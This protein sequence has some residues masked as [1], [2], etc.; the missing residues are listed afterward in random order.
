LA[1][2]TV[3]DADPP[4]TVAAAATAGFDAVGLWFDPTTWTA[5]TT[6]A[7]AR[8]LRA[9]GL[10]ALDIE[11]VILG[12][13]TDP[14]DALVKVIQVTPL[15]DLDAFSHVLVLTQGTGAKP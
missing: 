8:R 2:G 3:L 7:V 14:G 13:G 15:V 4:G 1:A 9:T 5:A 6:S 11:P 12:R 10:I